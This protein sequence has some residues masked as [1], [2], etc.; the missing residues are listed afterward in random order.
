MRTLEERVVY[1]VKRVSLLVLHTDLDVNLQVFPTEI[2]M[3]LYK[4]LYKF[5]M[6]VFN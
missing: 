4:F 2:M 3:F 5:R 1:I 6:V